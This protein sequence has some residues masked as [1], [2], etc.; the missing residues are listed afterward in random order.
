MKVKQFIEKIFKK[1]PDTIE[2]KEICERLITTLEEKVDDLVQDG[3]TKEEATN[4]AIAE[5]GDAKDFMT[6]YEKEESIKIKSKK[7][8]NAFYYSLMGTALSNAL[9]LFIG[10]YYLKDNYWWII[11]LIAIW[12]WPITMLYAYLNYR[13]KN[14]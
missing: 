9:I 5:F 8:L 13:S 6:E 10:L 3:K 4:I 2:K 1:Y 11:A 12:W 7:L 14:S